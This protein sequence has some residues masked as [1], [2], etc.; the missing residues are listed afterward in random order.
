MM[1][2]GIIVFL[3]YRAYRRTGYSPMIRVGVSFGF[4]GIASTV[5]EEGFKASE[6]GRLFSEITE[7]IGLVILLIAIIRSDYE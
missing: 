3:A 6:Y 1:V 5:V 4:I 2:G 7:V